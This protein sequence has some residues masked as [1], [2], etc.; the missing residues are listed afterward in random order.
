[1]SSPDSMRALGFRV[2]TAG[3][4]MARSVML[5]ELGVLFQ[6]V[7]I[8]ATRDA[9][10]R[11][12]IEDNILR[13]ASYNNRLS[14]STQFVLMYGLDPKLALFRNFRR[15]W[16]H[17]QGSQMALTLLMGM[18]RD[19]V[20]RACANDVID[21]AHGE[22]V[23]RESLIKVLD[24]FGS[25]RW[26]RN[27]LVLATGNVLNSL[28]QVGLITRKEHRR[29]QPTLGIT[30]I[31]FA[32]FLGRVEGAEGN[33]LFKTNWTRAL[34]QSARELMGQATTASHE[35]LIDLLNSGGVVEVRFPGYL[36]LEEQGL[37]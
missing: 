29:V 31:A 1:M 4:H 30:A 28:H 10:K 12:I 17:D 13:K 7:P 14:T 5:N 33:A 34:D 2:G 36:T 16:D 8:A 24:R 21:M 6:H 11:A 22:C 32:L 9:Y 25:G 37:L 26:S 23:D 27:V 35:G 3:A 20:F 18:A 15:L 19:P